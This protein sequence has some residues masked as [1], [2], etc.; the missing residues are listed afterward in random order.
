MYQSNSSTSIYDW[1]YTG[2]QS[3]GNDVFDIYEI[4]S[5]PQY[6]D[7]SLVASGFS[8]N[9]NTYPN[10]GYNSSDGYYYEYQGIVS[11][12]VPAF[13]TQPSSGAAISAYVAT[14]IAWTASSVVS[15]SGLSINNY[16]LQYSTANGSSWTTI[17]TVSGISYSWTPTSSISSVILRVIANQSDGT[18]TISSNS[19]PFSVVYQPPN[20]P[21]FNYITSNRSTVNKNAHIF[22]V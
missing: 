16:I 8:V 1:A 17:A 12:S 4:K 11:P 18:T 21:T 6:F 13:T 3:G 22:A 2:T 10:N 5:S 20:N 14:T 7:G 19:N 9:R 15:G